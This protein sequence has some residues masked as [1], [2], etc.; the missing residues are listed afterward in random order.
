MQPWQ[1]KRIWEKVEDRYNHNLQGYE[2]YLDNSAL[3]TPGNNTF[4]VPAEGLAKAIVSE[5]SAQ[6]DTINSNLM[7]F[8]LLVNSTIDKL[9]PQYEKVISD[10][11]AYGDTDLICYR[12]DAPEELIKLQNEKWDP[13]LDWL[14]TEFSISLVIVQGV[15]YKPQEPIALK[16]FERIIRSL[17][18]LTLTGLQ[19]L[20]TI[21]GSLAL[22]LTFYNDFLTPRKV[23]ELSNLDEN[24]QKKQWGLDKESE[25]ISKKKW[26][27]LKK[28]C[29]FLDL[30]KNK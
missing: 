23:W 22:A 25:I 9:I 21:S 8:T 10:L 1:K 12:A 7:P 19:E 17:D 24:W 4:L 11:V 2:I 3:R 13:I 14:L 26:E 30:L 29:N 6:S 5:W 16:R 28:A 20:I 18:Y 15:Q 27:N